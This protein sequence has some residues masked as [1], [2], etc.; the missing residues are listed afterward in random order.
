MICHTTTYINIYYKGLFLIYEYIYIYIYIY[1][2]IYRNSSN[3]YI[4][5]IE[6]CIIIRK[7]N[8]FRLH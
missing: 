7:L 8:N 6:N 4:I 5:H 1:E 2:I 3:K